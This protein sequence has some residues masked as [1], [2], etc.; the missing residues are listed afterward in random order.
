MFPLFFLQCGAGLA[1]ARQARGLAGKAHTARTGRCGQRIAY[2]CVGRRHGTLVPLRLRLA[3][4]FW[5]RAAGL[6]LFGRMGLHEGLWLRPCRAVHTVGMGRAIDVVF[7][8]RQGVVM[9]TVHALPP[10]RVAWCMRAHSV[11]ELPAFYCSRHAH[12]PAALRRAM[13]QLIE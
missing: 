12:Y 1:A 7:L 11:V 9:K 5:R 8:D 13:R 4:S 3:G 6:F 10:N 2:H